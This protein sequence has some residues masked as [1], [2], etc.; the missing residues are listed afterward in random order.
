MLC[1]RH[2]LKP[3]IPQSL[4]AF[5]TTT[6]AWWKPGDENDQCKWFELGA[7][8]VSIH[9]YVPLWRHIPDRHLA[10]VQTHTTLYQRFNSS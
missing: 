10:T 2:R 6:M 8:L 5:E 9:G 7:S 4:S 1:F 3:A